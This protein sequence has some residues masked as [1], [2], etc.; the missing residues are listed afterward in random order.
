MNASDKKK[1]TDDKFGLE[2]DYIDDSEDDEDE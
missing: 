1:F 2:K